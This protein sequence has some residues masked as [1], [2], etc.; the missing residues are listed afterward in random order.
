MLIAE[1]CDI[2]NV[3][4]ANMVAGI[5]RMIRLI[6]RASVV[7]SGRAACNFIVFDNAF[8]RILHVNRHGK[9][10]LHQ[11]MRNDVARSLNIHSTVFL[12]FG[13]G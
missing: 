13:S 9:R 2:V 10:A 6:N 4:V 11:I 7:C 3:I 12:V 8:L 1:R 5:R